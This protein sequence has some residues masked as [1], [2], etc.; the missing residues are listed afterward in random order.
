MSNQICP[1]TQM[2][3]LLNIMASQIPRGPRSVK[4]RK[5][6]SIGMRTPH[7]RMTFIIRELRVSP[8]PLNIASSM[9]IHNMN[10]VV[11]IEK[12]AYVMEFSIRYSEALPN[13]T[14]VSGADSNNPSTVTTAETATPNFKDSLKQSWVRR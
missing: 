4:L 13:N 6:Y 8:A 1:S 2:T 11:P 10:T 12:L 9:F 3:R 14:C 7:R 5:Q